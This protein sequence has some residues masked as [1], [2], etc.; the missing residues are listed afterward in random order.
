MLAGA[1][2]LLLPGA[3][4][5]GEAELTFSVESDTAWRVRTPRRIQKSQNR[6]S[7]EVEWEIARGLELRG[8]GWLLYDPV[9]RLVGDDPDFGQRPVD[10]WQVAGTRSLEAEL[11]EL[12]LD[13]RVRLGRARLDLRLGKQQVVWGQSFGLRVLDIVNPQ[14]F[15]EFI[16]DDFDESRIPLWGVQVE[17]PLGPVVADVVAGQKQLR[18]DHQVQVLACDRRL[19]A[20]QGDAPGSPRGR[21]AGQQSRQLRVEGEL[22]VE[23]G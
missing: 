7:L 15:R 18:A 3:P 19:Q 17:L 21:Q 1:V 6:A 2:A 12:H 13:W 16:L 22:A 9:R 20:R 14:D 4:A 8:L 11:R 10:R 5:R 23:V